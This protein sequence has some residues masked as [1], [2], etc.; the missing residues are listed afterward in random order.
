L[1]DI[2][3]KSNIKTIY[4]GECIKVFWEQQPS[5]NAVINL[6]LYGINDYKIEDN[7]FR[8][9]FTK[10]SSIKCSEVVIN[11]LLSVMFQ[12]QIQTIFNIEKSR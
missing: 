5:E 7:N 3:S 10:G 8:V 6:C 12:E 1:L 2:L 11:I 4:N 9:S